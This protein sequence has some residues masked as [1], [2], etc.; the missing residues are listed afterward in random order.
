NISLSKP[1]DVLAASPS[2]DSIVRKST[3][4]FDPTASLLD[5]E[6]HIN[7]G[8]K[9]REIRASAWTKI[10]LHASD[11]FEKRTIR[12]EEIKDITAYL[13]SNFAVLI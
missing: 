9:R 13:I 1:S 7:A 11:P 5:S 8:V 6:S 10:R 12:L 3:S 4:H 2:A